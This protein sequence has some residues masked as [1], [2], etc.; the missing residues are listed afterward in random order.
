M[1]VQ[2]SFAAAFRNEGRFVFASLKKAK[3]IDLRQIIPSAFGA[4]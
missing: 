3:L 4:D 2:S 1:E